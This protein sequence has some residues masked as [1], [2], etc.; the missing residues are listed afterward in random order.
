[1]NDGGNCLATVC[2]GE[3]DGC[4]LTDLCDIGCGSLLILASSNVKN[5][6][7]LQYVLLVGHGRETCNRNDVVVC[8]ILAQAIPDLVLF[9]LKLAST[10]GIILRLSYCTALNSSHL[11]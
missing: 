2:F 7:R 4:D 9:E 1:V 10:L 3:V 6:Y 5:H 11:S 8:V